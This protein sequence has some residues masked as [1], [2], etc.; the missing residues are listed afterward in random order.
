MAGRI[1]IGY[2]R[3]DVAGDARGLRD[4]LAAKFGQRNFFVDIDDLLPG[5]RF[6]V[7]LAE[8]LSGCDVFVAV[9]G[10]RWL[11]PL[12]AKTVLMKIRSGNDTRWV[13]VEL[14]RRP[15]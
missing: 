6:D 7:K 14:R 8:A 5:Q 12:A 2:R 15:G 10:P 1:F 13:A 4:G 3:E 9:I 11:E